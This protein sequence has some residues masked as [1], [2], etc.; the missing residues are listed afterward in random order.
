MI[1]RYPLSN[2]TAGLHQNSKEFQLTSS[3]PVKDSNATN[4]AQKQELISSYIQQHQPSSEYNHNKINSYLNHLY[5]LLHSNNNYNSNNN[6]LVNLNH[7]LHHNHTHIHHLLCNNHSNN[8]LTLNHIL[9]NIT[10]VYYF[11]QSLINSTHRRS[12]KNTKLQ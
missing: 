2:S 5:L 7:N 12:T 9:P 10:I 8:S 3:L 4:L 1:R 6:L 11:I